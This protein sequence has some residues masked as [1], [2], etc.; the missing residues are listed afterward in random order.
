MAWLTTPTGS[1][2]WTNELIER[3]EQG[4][5]SWEAIARGALT[6]MSES[7]VKDMAQSEEL[8]ED[9]EEEE[10]EDEEETEYLCTLDGREVKRV[11]TFT[12]AETWFRAY[13][14]DKTPDFEEVP[15]GEQ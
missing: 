8:A 10:D 2:D 13:D 9:P 7:D 6:Y 1:R 12:E 15:K 5:L 3:A 11:A 4:V 14:G